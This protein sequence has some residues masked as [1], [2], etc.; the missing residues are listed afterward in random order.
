VRR[1]TNPIAMCELASTQTMSDGNAP[2]IPADFYCHEVDIVLRQLASQA[3][4]I[5][6]L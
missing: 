6:E 5:A 4:R 1:M 2:R 3:A